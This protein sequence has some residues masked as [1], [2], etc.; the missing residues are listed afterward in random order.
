MVPV[1]LLTN[2]QQVGF[3]YGI[4]ARDAAEA[5]VA[6]HQVV[7]TKEVTFDVHSDSMRAEAVTVGTGE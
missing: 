1:N 4:S 6:G 5:V 2:I 7:W 3:D